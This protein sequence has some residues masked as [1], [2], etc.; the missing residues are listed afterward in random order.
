M[1][2]KG[3]SELEHI[4]AGIG[5]AN[6]DRSYDLALLTKFNSPRTGSLSN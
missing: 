1:D 2:M 4:E 3:K 6:S 5:I